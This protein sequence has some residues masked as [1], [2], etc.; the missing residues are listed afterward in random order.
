[1]TVELQRQL[2]TYSDPARDARQHTA[3][4]VFIATANAHPVAADDAQKAEIFHEH[5]LPDLAFDHARYS[6]I[7]SRS[8]LPV[9]SLARQDHSMQANGSLYLQTAELHFRRRR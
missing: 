6:R 4:T 1:M 9:P 3:S 2:H 8:K 5:N 7:T